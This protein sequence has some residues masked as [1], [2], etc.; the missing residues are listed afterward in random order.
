MKTLFTILTVSKVIKK[1]KRPMKRSIFTLSQVI[2]ELT[3]LL[4]KIIILPF[5]L[6]KTIKK[7][8]QSK[9]KIVTSKNNVVNFSD[10]KKKNK[11]S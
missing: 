6:Y 8:K 3:T 11:V 7:Y 9:N 10:Y 4:A 2:V 5:T 1:S